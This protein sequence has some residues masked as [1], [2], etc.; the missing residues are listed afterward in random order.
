MKW[1]N[2]KRAMPD[3]S[4]TDVDAALRWAG[5]TIARRPKSGPVLWR[6]NKRLHRQDEAFVIAQQMW[7]EHLAKLERGQVNIRKGK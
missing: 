4:A 5:F 2:R 1:R 3:Y 7:R 6:R